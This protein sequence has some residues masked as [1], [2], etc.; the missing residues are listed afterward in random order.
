MATRSD[1]EALEGRLELRFETVESRMEAMEARI[2]ERIH[3]Q[4]SS[5]YRTM[6][7]AIVGAVATVAGLAF[8]AAQLV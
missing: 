1:L 7:F 2:L 3:Q 5:L 8:A 6:I 4:V